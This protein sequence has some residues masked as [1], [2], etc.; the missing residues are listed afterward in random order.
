MAGQ[1]QILLHDQVVD[2]ALRP[3]LVQEIRRIYAALFSAAEGSVTVEIAE[4]PKGWFFTAAEPSTSS[5]IGGTVPAGTAGADRTRLM[6]EISAM[7]C[8]T[9]GCTPNELVVSVL[10]DGT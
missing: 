6:T 1:F 2:P 4:V 3:R 8:A 9:T 10:D 5:I 7:W